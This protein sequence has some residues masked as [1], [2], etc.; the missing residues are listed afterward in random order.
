MHVN[1]PIDLHRYVNQLVA[2][3]AGSKR[4]LEEYLLA[5][6]KQI[7][8][9]RD[10]QP[11]YQDIANFLRDSYTGEPAKYSKDWSKLPVLLNEAN[12]DAY[13]KEVESYEYVERQLKIYIDDLHY[14][15]TS[16]RHVLFGGSSVDGTKGRGG[17][18]IWQRTD[19]GPF[20]L[21]AV[22]TLDAEDAEQEPCSW[23]FLD[24]LLID[25]VSLE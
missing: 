17:A 6:L 12:T 10:K 13:Y 15:R 22:S 7:Q 1:N 11:T 18:I 23:G 21:A 2:D 5:L 25:G 20:L 14:I 8:A 3:N 19:L 24:N 4:N 9:A 16:I